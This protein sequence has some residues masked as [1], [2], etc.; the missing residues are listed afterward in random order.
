M[1]RI[2]K[3]IFASLATVLICSSAHASLDWNLTLNKSN[4]GTLS[5][6]ENVYAQATLYNLASSTESLDL[7]LP[8]GFGLYAVKHDGISDYQ[9]NEG[10]GHD[11]V[12]PWLDWSTAM[13]KIVLAPGESKTFDF[14][15]LWSSSPDGIEQ[16]AYSIQA[17]MCLGSGFGCSGLDTRTVTLNWDV[18]AVPEPSAPALLLL[19]V[20]LIVISMRRRRA[21]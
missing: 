9:Y 12:F 5:A 14:F 8:H 1:P 11:D 10:F 17:E 20:G 16:G 7:S 4:L 21:W 6:T 2:I 19:G 3:L 18:A 13:G 15:W